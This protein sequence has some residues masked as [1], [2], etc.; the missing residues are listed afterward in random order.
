MYLTLSI[1][2]KSFYLV[3]HPDGL[4]LECF[5]QH[6]ALMAQQMCAGHR[7]SLAL[8]RVLLSAGGCVA[9]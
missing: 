2:V 9:G 5:P 7:Q 8:Q 3:N 1:G 6:L 4:L